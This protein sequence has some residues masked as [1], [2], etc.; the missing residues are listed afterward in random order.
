MSG[1]LA[2]LSWPEFKRKILEK[3]CNEQDLDKI[4]DEYREMKKGNLPFS[5]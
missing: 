2:K 4:E 5:Y 3:Y 1:V